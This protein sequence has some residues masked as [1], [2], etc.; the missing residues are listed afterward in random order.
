MALN[1]NLKVYSGSSNNILAKKISDFLN[2][3]LGQVELSR[4]A[5]NECR[6]WIKDK[7]K[8]SKAVIVQSFSY[9]PDEHLIEFLF[10][11]DAL[12]RKGAKKII[13]VIP[14]F[15]Y[16]IQDKVFRPGEPLSSKVMARLLQS[17]KVSH[18]ITLD[19]HNETISGFFDMPFTHLKA[20]DVFIDYFKNKK[21]VD[22]IVSPDVGALKNATVFAQNMNLPL[23]IINKA[24]NLATGKVSIVGVS[25]EIKGKSVLIPD[26]FISTGGTLVQTAKF[27]K[28]R[29]VKKVY[30]ALTHHF[31]VPG[32]Q[33]KIEKSS[34]DMLYVTDTIKKPVV[35]KYKKLT[36]I[37]VANLLA[38]AINKNK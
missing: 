31:Y 3:K 1:K 8:I 2:V 7:E 19:L 24:R 23:V 28:D 25:G 5:N 33:E 29:G 20:R 4:F 30:A 18:T 27:L 35:K 6:V 21:I 32:V 37:S 26:D 22:T 15:G 17:V 16:C 13:A 34:L 36:I 11:V 9:P 14:W 12:K 10:M 38:K